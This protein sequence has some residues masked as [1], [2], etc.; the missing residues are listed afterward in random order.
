MVHFARA[1]TENDAVPAADGHQ[2]FF[3]ESRWIFRGIH[4]KR[5]HGKDI[6]QNISLVTQQTDNLKENAFYI[7]DDKFLRILF[8]R[9]LFYPTLMRELS[10]IIVKWYNFSKKVNQT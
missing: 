8:H 3:S 2:V 9:P 7:T 5:R 10:I 1:N 4:E 6:H